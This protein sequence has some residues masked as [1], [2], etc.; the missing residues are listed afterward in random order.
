MVDAL[1]REA[2]HLGV[3]RQSIIKVWIAGYAVIEVPTRERRRAGGISKVNVLRVG[4]FYVWSL[5]VG[6]TQRR[7]HNGVTERTVTGPRGNN[8]AED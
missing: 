1:D 6:L 3:T 7:R 8:A 2:R 4:H 5:L